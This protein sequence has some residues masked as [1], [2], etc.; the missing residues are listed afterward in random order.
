V[1]RVNAVYLKWGNE[2]GVVIVDER[3][4]RPMKISSV[5]SAI[6]NFP[7]RLVESTK[8]GQS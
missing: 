1:A 4:A 8:A 6:G 2:S 7:V 5:E 3:Q